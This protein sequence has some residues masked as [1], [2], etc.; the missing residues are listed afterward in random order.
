MTPRAGDAR[1]LFPRLCCGR[2]VT[3]ATP[4]ARL[5]PWARVWP[6]PAGLSGYTQLCDSV[7]VGVILFRDAGGAAAGLGAYAHGDPVEGNGALLGLSEEPW[8]L[9]ADTRPF[10]LGSRNKA[11]MK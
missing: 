10:V 8:G 5:R 1:Q 4:S 7:E 2:P 11:C 9:W 3:R 6:E